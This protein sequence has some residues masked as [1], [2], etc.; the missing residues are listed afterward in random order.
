MKKQAQNTDMRVFGNNV[1]KKRHRTNEKCLLRGHTSAF[2]Q[3][4][5]SSV[6]VSLSRDI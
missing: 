2:F 3:P 1:K 4:I 6:Y 5:Y